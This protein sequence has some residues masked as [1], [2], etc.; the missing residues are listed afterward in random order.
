MESRCYWDGHAFQGEAVRI[1]IEQ[2]T[3]GTFLLDTITFCSFPC[4]MGHITKCR[5]DPMVL[6]YLQMYMKS[7]G[8]AF[9]N[10]RS[11]HDPR[12]LRVYRSDGNGVDIVEF[13]NGTATSFVETSMNDSTSPM[14]AVEDK[15]FN[16]VSLN[17]KEHGLSPLEY[18]E[19]E[20]VGEV[21]GGVEKDEE[22]S[23]NMSD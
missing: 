16:F 1:P 23:I 9:E 5:Q 8:V 4:A 17:I 13:R 11:A 20:V 7:L 19:E 18:Y 22:A 6:V 14:I 21:A 10:M 3:D 2:K 12:V 15:Q